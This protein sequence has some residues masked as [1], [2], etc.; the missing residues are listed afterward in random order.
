VSL[1]RGTETLNRCDAEASSF[2]EVPGAKGPM[3]EAPYHG[4]VTSS[5]KH[6]L[7][8]RKLV[9]ARPSISS[10]SKY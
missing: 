1:A 8:Q 7:L 3:E 5:T 4:G 6:P 9:V 10:G 2:E